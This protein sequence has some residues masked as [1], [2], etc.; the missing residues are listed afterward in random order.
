[1]LINKNH[2]TQMNFL[3]IKRDFKIEVMTILFLHTTKNSKSLIF[4]FFFICM[5]DVQILMSKI[6]INLCYIKLTFFVYRSIFISNSTTTITKECTSF[7]PPPHQ[8]QLDIS[9]QFFFLCLFT[10]S[11]L[12]WFYSMHNKNDIWIAFNWHNLNRVI[13][14]E[15]LEDSWK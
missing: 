10:S 6:T 3:L 9:Q 14:W 5:N 4:F 2:S 12:L 13:K 7:C 11:T 1:M 15:L 8:H